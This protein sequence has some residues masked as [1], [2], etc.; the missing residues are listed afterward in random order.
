MAAKVAKLA[1]EEL[2]H[3]SGGTRDTLGLIVEYNVKIGDTLEKIASDFK[4]TVAILEQLNNL[5][6]GAKLRPGTTIYVDDNR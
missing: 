3:A 4:T 2:A 6:P 1:K 5:N